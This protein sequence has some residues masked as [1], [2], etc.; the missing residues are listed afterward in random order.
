MPLRP[1]SAKARTRPAAGVIDSSGERPRPEDVAEGGQITPISS[2]TGQTETM[3]E[4]GLQ[5]ILVAEDEVLV[6][7]SVAEYLRATG[8]RVIE[9]ANA[10]EALTVLGAGLEVDLVFSDIVMP[11]DIDGIGLAR[12]MR[13]RFPDIPVV[14]TS[15][16]QSR[17]TEANIADGFIRK[18][19]RA[20]ALAR[21][22]ARLLEHRTG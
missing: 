10:A 14:L 9:A 18:P 19:Y 3:E 12:L 13:R 2:T 4:P 17:A 21:R 11:G 16:D 6:R 22:F 5:T 7:S 8:H 1:R 15:G 20:S